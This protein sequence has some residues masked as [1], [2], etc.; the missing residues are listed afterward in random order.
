ML[1]RQRPTVRTDVDD[2][3]VG[4]VDFELGRTRTID[5]DLEVAMAV[6]RGLLDRVIQRVHHA[7]VL[8]AQADAA[9]SAEVRTA[10]VELD[11]VLRDV[12]AEVFTWRSADSGPNH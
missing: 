1:P 4:W 12:T 2:G 9:D 10:I 3:A 7:G 6:S 11:A 8:L 5:N